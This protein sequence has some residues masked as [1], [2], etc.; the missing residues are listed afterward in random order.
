MLLK[1]VV[2]RV[3]FLSGSRRLSVRFVLVG[4]SNVTPKNALVTGHLHS[5][6]KEVE[7]GQGTAANKFS[8]CR[9]EGLKPEAP[10]D[11]TSPLNP[12][13]YPYSIVLS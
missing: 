7:S 6:T 8:L 9:V 5:M 2:G 3:A 1:S 11:H 10:D 12:S 4:L 13:F